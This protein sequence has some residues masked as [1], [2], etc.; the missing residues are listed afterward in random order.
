MILFH[1]KGTSVAPSNFQILGILDSFTHFKHF[2]FQ[3][4][5]AEY[6]KITCASFM[7][8]LR[9]ILRCR[10]KIVSVYFQICKGYLPVFNK[11]FH[12]L[13]LYILSHETIIIVLFNFQIRVERI[14]QEKRDQLDNQMKES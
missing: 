5:E 14:S 9:A 4:R 13:A 11:S 1:L 2:L 3:I 8:H 12:V 6:K 7:H 10:L